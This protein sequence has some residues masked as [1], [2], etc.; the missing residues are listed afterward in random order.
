M[1][2][3]AILAN[4]SFLGEVLLFILLLFTKL[5]I[6]LLLILIVFKVC[7][8]FN[9]SSNESEDFY[10][11]AFVKSGNKF[12][13]I[14]EKDEDNTSGIKYSKL[15]NIFDINND[16]Y[17]EFNFSEND[18]EDYNYH[19]ESIF[20]LENNKYVEYKNCIMEDD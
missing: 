16:S 13:K 20:R 3:L 14:F 15:S 9:S 4:G 11:Y 17:F 18:D 1:K 8:E 10:Q 2:I 6:A 5:K 7:L 12:I 19:C